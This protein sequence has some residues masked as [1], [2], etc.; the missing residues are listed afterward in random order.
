MYESTQQCH[1][2]Y[3]FILVQDEQFNIYILKVKICGYKYTA[4][5]L[6]TPK[7]SVHI[8]F[9]LHKISHL[10]PKKA[11]AL[12]YGLPSVAFSVV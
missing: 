8:F 7:A 5:Y 3:K 4:K 2:F 10:I 9:S 1:C 12:L 6:K 11:H